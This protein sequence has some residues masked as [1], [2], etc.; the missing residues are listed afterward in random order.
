MLSHKGSG[1]GS[2]VNLHVPQINHFCNV[3]SGKLKLPELVI[4]PD[5]GSKYT[6]M[7]IAINYS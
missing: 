6:Y 7:H 3:L 1:S 2:K 5:F 4:F